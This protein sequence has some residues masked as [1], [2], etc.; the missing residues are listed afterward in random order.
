MADY[1]D[2]WEDNNSIPTQIGNKKIKFFCDIACISC[3]VCRENAP[4]NFKLSKIGNHSICF[5]Q[6]KN[7]KE[8][9]ECEEAMRC[10]PVT[11][12]GKVENAKED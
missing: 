2:K 1:K 10:C 6:P 5:K 9:E 7:Q 8:L 3:A 4:N 11:A 12:I